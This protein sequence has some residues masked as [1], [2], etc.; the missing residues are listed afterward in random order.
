ML[1]F[2]YL[3]WA[4]FD[5]TFNINKEDFYRLPWQNHSLYLYLLCCSLHLEA[6]VFSSQTNLHLP[7]QPYL[8]LFHLCICAYVHI[9]P[10]SW[11]D[12]KRPITR[13]IEGTQQHQLK[14]KQEEKVKQKERQSRASNESQM[15]SIITHTCAV[16]E[17]YLA[18][19]FLAVDMKRKTLVTQFTV[20]RRY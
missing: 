8:R 9:L 19:R 11:K 12:R 5:I 15:H 4:G 16:G 14:V 2:R 18:L 13:H 17:S 6:P 20:S 1:H 3:R 7:L 10:F